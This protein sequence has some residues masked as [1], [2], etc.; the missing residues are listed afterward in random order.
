LVNLKQLG[1]LALGTS[2]SIIYTV[3]ASTNTIIKEMA[4]CNT[5]S[6][7]V[8]VNVYMVPSGGTAGA[9]N[10]VISGYSIAAN[11]PAFFTGL[12]TIIPAGATI[13]GSASASGVTI[14]ISGAEVS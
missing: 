7:A 10:A 6:S 8:S 14:T 4:I 2:A 5:S 9:T 13:Q 12:N 3:P 11:L 1:Q